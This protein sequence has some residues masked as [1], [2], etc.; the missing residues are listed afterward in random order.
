[1]LEVNALEKRGSQS[2]NP[3]CSCACRDCSAG[4]SL[5]CPSR[6]PEIKSDTFNHRAIG[7][8]ERCGS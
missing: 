6:A 5:A 4:L 7:V 2:V 1:M 8:E 3:G